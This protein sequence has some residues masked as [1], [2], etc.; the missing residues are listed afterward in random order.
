MK[1]RHSLCKFSVRR[2]HCSTYSLAIC[3]CAGL[4]LGSITAV[5]MSDMLVVMLHNC[6][7]IRPLLMRIICVSLL[8]F[9]LSA[10]ALYID[11]P[12]ILLLIAAIKSFGFG[13]CA[14][15]VSLAFE[16]SSWLVRSFFLF[17]DV[18]SL[19]LLYFYLL[20]S[21]SGKEKLS[22]HLHAVLFCVFLG[23]GIV[24]YCFVSPFWVA[25]HF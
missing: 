25:L 21:I 17:S 9:L 22:I 8:P 3:W 10:F 23:I 11:E 18:I 7:F 19:P 1:I 20:R 16:H 24:D 2:L 13:F 6:V 15:G 14:A 5:S 12:W 4:V